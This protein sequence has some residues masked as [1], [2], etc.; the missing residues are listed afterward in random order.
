MYEEELNDTWEY[1]WIDEKDTSPVCGKC[2]YDM[3]WVILLYS[4]EKE[5]CF[6]CKNIKTNNRVSP[7]QIKQT[8]DA[9]DLLGD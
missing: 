1:S 2:A 5:E 4:N 8:K 3:G 9:S 6:L 7:G